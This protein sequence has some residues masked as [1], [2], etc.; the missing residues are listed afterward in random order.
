MPK[1]SIVIPNYNGEAYLEECLKSLKEQMFKDFEVIMVDNGST[2]Q[3]TA[4]AKRIYPEIKIIEFKKNMG[5][6]KAVNVG[7]KSSESPYVILLN[8]DTI[9]FPSF[10]GN[11]Y[12]MISERPDVFSCSALMINNSKRNLIDDAGDEFCALGWGFAPERDKKVD[13]YKKVREVFSSCAGAAIYR[14]KIFD[15]I[16]YFDEYF[17]A[18]LEDMDVGY[19]SRLAGYI[20]L[21]NPYAKLY[22]IG[23]ASSGSRHNAFKVELSARNSIYLIRKNMP[24]WQQFMNLPFIL[25][26]IVIKTVYFAR[27]RLAKPY[28]KGI[29]SGCVDM[30]DKNEKKYGFMSYM[31]VQGWLFRGIKRRIC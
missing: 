18:Y 4:C 15:E 1:V 6:A 2:D 3:S 13:D 10:V 27:K 21:Y 14:K 7:I 5:F 31:K 28:L 26:G 8:N 25:T 12:K 29:F 30:V 22:H 17:F 16:G 9:V 19:R 24:K 23:S 11:Q 20:N